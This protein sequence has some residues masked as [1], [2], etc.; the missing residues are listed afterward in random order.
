MHRTILGGLIGAIVRRYRR[1]RAVVHL[2]ELN[3]HLLRDIGIKR[4][5][6]RHVVDGAGRPEK[7]VRIDRPARPQTLLLRPIAD[8]RAVR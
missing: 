4:S 3:D 8:R 2:S 7:P 5:D 1:R 6:I